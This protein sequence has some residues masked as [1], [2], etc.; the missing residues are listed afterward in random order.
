MN[1]KFQDRA[2]AAALLEK[3]LTQF[4]NTR[5]VILAVPRGGV[6]LGYALAKSLHLPL[7]LLMA[8]KIGHPFNREYAIGSV[9]LNDV[10]LNENITDVS[11]DYVVRESGRIQQD[12]VSRYQK[13]M[14]GK[15]PISLR[16]KKVIIVDDGIATGYTLKACLK[17]LRHQKP[18]RI[19][20]AVPVAPPESLRRLQSEADEIICLQ[21]PKNFNS[22]SQYYD[23]FE[24]VTDEDIKKMMEALASHADNPSKIL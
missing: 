5:S 17:S 11:H 15:K 14:K 2:H 21:Q 22:V 12:L 20:V 6:A 8:K 13:L 10:I 23:H 7:D 18:S 16:A 1:F 4:R 19:I 24:E 9:T 3:S